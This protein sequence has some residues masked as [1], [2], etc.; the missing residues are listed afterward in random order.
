MY[1][2][3]EEN[4]IGKNGQRIPTTNGNTTIDGTDDKSRSR[5]RLSGGGITFETIHAQAKASDDLA[6]GSKPEIKRKK[7]VTDNTLPTE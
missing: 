4:P 5:T 6:F 1:S 2:L 3:L 7:N